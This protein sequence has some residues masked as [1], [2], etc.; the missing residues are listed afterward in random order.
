MK[1]SVPCPDPFSV[2]TCHLHNLC[3]LLV[4]RPC[5][6]TMA[7]APWVM[8]DDPP[9]YASRSVKARRWLGYFCGTILLVFGYL[10]E[11]SGPPVKYTP[12]RFVDLSV[13]ASFLD[14]TALIV[15]PVV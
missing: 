5:T 6:P 2:L 9:C 13:V 11:A 4:Q 14:N 12:G 15:E 10:S 1:V 3:L 8:L 7:T